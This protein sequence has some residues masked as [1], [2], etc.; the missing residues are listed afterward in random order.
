MPAQQYEKKNRP[1]ATKHAAQTMFRNS[2]GSTSKSVTSNRR[3]RS[4]RSYSASKDVNKPA[5]GVT[6]I[7]EP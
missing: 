4:I 7:A 2:L 6:S 5:R 1:K 3:S